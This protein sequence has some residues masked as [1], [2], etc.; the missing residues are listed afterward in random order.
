[1]ETEEEA[2]DVEYIDPDDFAL[3][4][5]GMVVGFAVGFAFC[6]GGMADDIWTPQITVNGS[7]AYDTC[8]SKNYEDENWT[9]SHFIHCE[10]T[11]KSCQNSKD[12]LITYWE[13]RSTEKYAHFQ[14]EGNF[15]GN[16]LD[17]QFKL[18]G[19]THPGFLTLGTN[20]PNASNYEEGSV[21]WEI[22]KEGQ[23]KRERL[24][25]GS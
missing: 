23:E 19:P 24:G 5:Y 8:L 3:L 4:A 9:S 20:Y 25:G 13:N 2:Q 17:W 11:L 1:V 15:D 22:W 18:K 14:T 12:C 10:N 21:G 6:V 7:T 16:Y